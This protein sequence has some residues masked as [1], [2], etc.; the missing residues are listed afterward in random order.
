LYGNWS[1]RE[2]SDDMRDRF[3]TREQQ[4][5]HLHEDIRRMVHFSRLNL[6]ETSYPALTNGTWALDLILC[7]NVTIYFNEAT[8][9]AM[10]D[11]FY[12]ALL[13]GGWLIVGHA[14]PHTGIYQQFEVHNFPNAVIYRKPLDAPPFTIDLV[15]G[16]FN[17]NPALPVVTPPAQPPVYRPPQPVAALP[18]R[19]ST[20]QK[21]P[22]RLSTLS[23]SPAKAGKPAR[24][25][26]PET[27]RWER[28]SKANS[29][30]GASEN[31]LW[32]AIS[33]R[34]AEG[35][36]ATA[37]TLLRDM[38]RTHPN[39]SKALTAL[40]RLCADRGEWECARTFCENAIRC[41]ALSLEAHYILAQIYEHQGNLDAALA[42]YRRTV[43][44]DRAF[45]LGMMG[46]ANIWRQMG[47]TNEAQRG[48][49]NVL[50]Q[51]AGLAPFELV[52][53]ADGVTVSELASLTMHQLQ[54]LK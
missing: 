47:R 27:R 1:F 43:Y 15:G 45:V 40:G 7:R 24:P 16:M 13:P 48:Y 26:P 36:K 28:P 32:T 37:E 41:D 46:M 34:L 54:A 44:L 42:E 51:L 29:Q 50:K 31:D 39:H 22:S 17:A 49:R 23:D 9:R 19:T 11:R 2:I 33:D 35:D 14:E 3:F 12:R 30:P 38:L 4:R 18:E 21:R 8:T 10:V 53:G 52:R 6:V 20:A 5:W 25:A